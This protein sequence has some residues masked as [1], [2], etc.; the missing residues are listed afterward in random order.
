M[1]PVRVI[2]SET[3]EEARRKG[4]ISFEV[5]PGDI[6]TSLARESAERIG[7]R[8]VEGPLERPAPP[9][10]DGKT[11]MRRA[12][13]RRSPRW[14]PPSRAPRKARKI[15]RLALIGAGGV[16][17]ALAHLAAIGGVAREIAILDVAPGLAASLALDLEHASGITRASAKCV[18]GE[19]SGLL[20][21]A[22][23]VVVSAGRPRAPGMSRADLLEANARVIRLAGEAIRS[24]APDAI[25]IVITNPLDEMTVEMLRAA[26]FPRERVLGMAGTLDGARFRR[27]LADAAGVPPADVEAIAL[28]SHGEEMVP[29]P[30]LARIRGRPLSAFL[31]AERIE[32]CAREAVEGGAKLVELRRSGSA[33]LAPAHAA[34]ELI[35]HIRGSRI[36]PVPA[37]VML[38]GEYGIEGIALGVPVHLG[39]GGLI[40]VEEL[41]LE[42]GELEALRVAARAIRERLGA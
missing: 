32:S 19:D 37:S 15:S 33:T 38:E 28:G 9:R 6:V 26:G 25:V 40:R 29:L 13:H 5:L 3:L 16:G 35:D 12:L 2:G 42:A 20:A 30:S 18:G 22:E 14:A 34:L 31:G 36:G 7:I 17:S 21:D 27:A 10:A 8:L 39:R 23:L 24:Q 1:S 11:A 41:R 4:R